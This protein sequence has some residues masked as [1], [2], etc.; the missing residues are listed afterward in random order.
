LERVNPGPGRAGR[1][2]DREGKPVI[3]MLNG[4]HPSALKPV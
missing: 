4:N 3:L 1:R 2:P